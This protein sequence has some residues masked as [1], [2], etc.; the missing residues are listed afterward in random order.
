MAVLSALVHI[1]GLPSAAPLLVQHG[2]RSTTWRT[3][4]GA[5]RLLIAGLLSFQPS[6]SSPPS[7]VGVTANQSKKNERLV[8][9]GR[10]QQTGGR[11][12][13]DGRRGGGI[14]GGGGDDDTSGHDDFEGGDN[15]SNRGTGGGG[16]REGWWCF[17][18]E[19]LPMP[20]NKGSGVGGAGQAR[21]S[22]ME[23]DNEK[24]LRDVG[25]LLMDERP[26]VGVNPCPLVLSRAG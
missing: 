1:S 22:A 4:E 17:S 19:G 2:L 26:E 10:G 20:P 8:G 6:S 3:R 16:D 13:E 9:G 5:L 15:R 24:L 21:S 18:G 12:G 11:A 25:S 23:M 7:G 14:G